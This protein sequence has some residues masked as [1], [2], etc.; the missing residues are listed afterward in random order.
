MEPQPY[1][2]RYLIILFSFQH[3]FHN[4]SWQSQHKGMTRQ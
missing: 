4:D 2:V 1:L 3:G